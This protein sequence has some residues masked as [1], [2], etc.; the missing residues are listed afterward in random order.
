MKT[1]IKSQAKRIHALFALRLPVGSGILRYSLA[2]T[3]ILLEG[4]QIFLKWFKVFIVLSLILVSDF[5]SLFGTSF[6]ATFVKFQP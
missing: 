3:P 4:D 6:N 2:V 5:I 1:A